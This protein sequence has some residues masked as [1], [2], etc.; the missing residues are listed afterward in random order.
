M[1]DDQTPP[2]P[3]PAAAPAAPATPTPA[4]PPAAPATPADDAINKATEILKKMDEK[5][6]SLLKQTEDLEAR[7]KE[8]E[9]RT[10]EAR[11][12]GFGRY[13]PPKTEDQKNIDAA[14][15]L[16]D[17]TGLDVSAEPYDAFSRTKKKQ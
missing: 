5:Q 16:M 6:A 17:G 11:L 2:T 3:P 12:G 15:S 13:L 14:N 10:T 1:T 9:R 8:L 4:A 7:E